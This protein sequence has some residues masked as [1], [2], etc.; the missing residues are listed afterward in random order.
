MNRSETIRHV[1]LDIEGTTCPIHFVSEVL[2]P[3]ASQQLLPFLTEHQS[4]AVVE[5]LLKEVQETLANDPSPEAIALHSTTARATELESLPLQ[6]LCS[7]LAWL[8]KTDRKVTALKELQGMIW[9][10]GYQRGELIAPLFTDVPKALAEWHGK[11]I[12][13]SVYSSGS[14]HAQKLLYAHSEF[15]DISNLFSQWFDT[16]TGPKNMASSYECIAKSLQTNPQEIL[17][18]SDAVAELEAASSAKMAVLF[19]KRANNPQQ[20]PNG[21]PTVEDYGTLSL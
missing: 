17:F 16:R 11:G 7:Y 14:V 4:E 18:I 9:E 6:T 2:F 13:L 12:G 20:D 8:I 3:Y 10:E 19:S 5:K 1:L 15:G 21:F